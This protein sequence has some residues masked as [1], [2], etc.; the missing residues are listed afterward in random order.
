MVIAQEFRMWAAIQQLCSMRHDG[1]IRQ[2]LFLG[3]ASKVSIFYRSQPE[4][5]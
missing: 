1:Q 3:E 2:V 5:S 4:A